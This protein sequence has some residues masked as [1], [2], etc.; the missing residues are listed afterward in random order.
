MVSPIFMVLRI[1]GVVIG[2]WAAFEQLYRG[3]SLEAIRQLTVWTVASLGIIS[4]IGNCFFNKDVAESLGWRTGS[5]FQKELGFMHF[6]FAFTALINFFFRAGPQAD[7]TLLMPYMIFYLM[8]ALLHLW[9]AVHFRRYTWQTITTIILIFIMI[10]Y[11]AF[12]A[13]K[14]IQL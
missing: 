3:H 8:C 1:I 4:G 9:N 13:V 14:A 11:V 5:N 7:I 12:F 10:A 2:V 6:A